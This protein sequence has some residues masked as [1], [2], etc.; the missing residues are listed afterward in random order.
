MGDQLTDDHLDWATKFTGKDPR[1]AQPA[2]QPGAQPD[3][4]PDAQPVATAAGPPPPPAPAAA[5]SGMKFSKD[6]PLPPIKSKACGGRIDIEVAPVIK[7]SGTGALDDADATHIDG[8]GLAEGVAKAALVT[9]TNWQGSTGKPAVVSG[10]LYSN[11]KVGRQGTSIAATS[12]T[13]TPLGTFNLTVTF[14]GIGVKAQ[15]ADASVK[16]TLKV[17]EAKAEMIGHSVK[18]PDTEI[19]GIKLTD[20]TIETGASVTM[21]PN[22]AQII[23]QW[24]LETGGK[25]LVVNAGEGLGEAAVAVVSIEGL[26]VVGGAAAVGA[27]IYAIVN[28][29]GIGDLAQSYRPS[30]DNARAGFKAG[31]SWGSPPG[32]Q[33]GKAGFQVGAQ[34]AQAL[35]DRTKK[36]NPDATDDAIKQAVAAK[37]DDALK[38]VAGAIDYNVRKGLWDGYLAQHTTL[39]ISSDA[40]WAFVACFGDFPKD[41]DPNWKAYQAQHPIQSKM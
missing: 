31:M 36:A 38:E 40:R 9:A 35:F 3:S 27:S 29:W 41:N 6:V 34:N 25:E 33:Y 28:A 17:L 11:L 20:L 18:L 4:Q 22:W 16:G 37:A 2:A 14:I 8:V 30:L 10:N 24:A 5:S 23:A 13:S 15:A 32:D 7:I 1:S 19:A 26:I 12:T 21:G 39:L